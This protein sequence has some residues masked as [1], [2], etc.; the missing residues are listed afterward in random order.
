MLDLIPT[1]RK[2][3]ARAV[4]SNPRSATPADRDGRASLP[5]RIHGG[6]GNGR[7]GPQANGPRSPVGARSDG[8]WTKRMRVYERWAIGRFMNTR[9]SNVQFS[10]AATASR[11]K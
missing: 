8:Y 6:P 7:R 5:G 11:R 3:K 1:H 2:P 4:M 9:G 10:T